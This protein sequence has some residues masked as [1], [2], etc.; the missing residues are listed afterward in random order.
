VRWTEV[1]SHNFIFG[2]QGKF[3]LDV[4]R[5]RAFHQPKVLPVTDLD[6]EGVRIGRLGR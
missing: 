5:A 4:L 6:P 2:E 1:S 3:R